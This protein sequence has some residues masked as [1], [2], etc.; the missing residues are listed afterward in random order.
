LASV[1]QGPGTAN[2]EAFRQ[3]LREYGYIE[4]ENVIVE[5]RWGDSDAERFPGLATE[6]VRLPV[7]VILAAGSPA[8]V[9]A[10]RATATIPI[11]FAGAP[12]PVGV[13]LVGNLGRPD[14]NATGTSSTVGLQLAG[15]RLELISAAVPGASRAAVITNPVQGSAGEWQETQKAALA[16]GLRARAQEVRESG[17]LEGALEIAKDEADVLVVMRSALTLAHRTQIVQVAADSRLPAIFDGNEFVDVGG[18]MAYGPRRADLFRRAAYYVDRILKGASPADL[19]VEQPMTFE[20]LINLKA[21]QA[22]GLTI[23]QHVLLQ[24]TEVIQ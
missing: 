4:N 10:Q 19:P 22:L 9:A 11:V 18:L 20:F 6:L 3:G 13:G 1:A 15:K 21:A 17:Q 14:R 23:P 2:T 7:D 8:A 24:A 12:D 5:Y 16:L